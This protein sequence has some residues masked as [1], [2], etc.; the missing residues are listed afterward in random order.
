MHVTRQKLHLRVTGREGGK[1]K[2]NGG[3]EEMVAEGLSLLQYTCCCL[4]LYR[5]RF[6]FLIGNSLYRSHM[7]AQVNRQ[8]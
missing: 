2:Q 7:Q 5:P 6:L 1:E 8:Y 4:H 3:D